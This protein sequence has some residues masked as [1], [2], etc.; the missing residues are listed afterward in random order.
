MSGFL[1][2]FFR[3]GFDHTFVRYDEAWLGLA[4]ELAHE[5][6]ALILSDLGVKY[7]ALI[8][9]GLAL[10]DALERVLETDAPLQ[11][12]FLY[13][14]SHALFRRE[15]QHPA[16]RYYAQLMRVRTAIELYYSTSIGPRLWIMHGAGAIIGPRHTIG[17]DFTFYQGVTLGHSRR[18]V[19]HEN[20]VIGDGCTIFAGA[21]VLGALRLGD[22]V[23]V[24]ANAVLLTDAETDGV[25]I[26][27]PARKYER[28]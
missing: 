10:E 15:P 12:T 18:F 4:E 22:R 27:N 23:K 25:Y 7:P 3:H 17:S 8:E 24:G 19:P 9:Q 11:A 28:K 20:M 5:Q 2:A 1:A 21:K 16:L 13:R 6:S 14:I 26:G